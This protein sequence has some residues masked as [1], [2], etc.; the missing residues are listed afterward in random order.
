MDEHGDVHVEKL[1]TVRVRQDGGS[2]GG[3]GIGGEPRAVRG[4]TRK[5]REQITGD[6]VAAAQSDAGDPQVPGVRL[7][8][9]RCANMVGQ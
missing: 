7:G 9:Q 3:D 5:R 4:R 1:H 8:R 6:D 2:T